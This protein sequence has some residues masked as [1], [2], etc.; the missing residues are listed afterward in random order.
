MQHQH[1]IV[2][3]SM[4][5]TIVAL[6]VLS[7]T[8]AKWLGWTNWF[9][10]QV[11]VAIVPITHPFTIVVDTI[12]PTR[13]SDPAASERE[14][15]VI[16]ELQ[17]VQFEL[18]QIRQENQRLKTQIDYYERGDAIT[19]Q[20][21][22]K[23]VTRP[24]IANLTG[25]LLLVRTGSIE[26]LSQGTVV[27]ADAVQLLGRVARVDGRTSTVLPITAASAQPIMAAVLLNEDGSRQ[28]RCLLKPV[29]DGTL[30]GDVA[31]PS[32]DENTN[33]RVGQEVRLQ[34]SQW[35]TNAQMLLV[36]H[37]ER[38]ERNEK[39]P[40]RPSIIVRPTVD[41]LRRVPEVILRIPITDEAQ[42]G[43]P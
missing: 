33:I 7:F 12:V 19:P 14:Q 42:G 25:D 4:P 41:D 20:L 18:L 9:T 23:Q 6:L 10:A 3:W 30:R 5:I 17:R 11:N 31:R 35:P 26:G 32:L 2:R 24:R 29:G 27:V 22:V 38:V 16:D 13:I 34:D 36:G 28:A 39:Q 21:N 40:L 1:L 43:T 8:P 15:A 37:I